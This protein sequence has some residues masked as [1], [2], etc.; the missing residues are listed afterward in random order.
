PSACETGVPA[1]TGYVQ[2]GEV[3]ASVTTFTD[4]NNGNGLN[5]GATYC[6]LIY[7]TFPGPKKGESLASAEVCAEVPI[8]TSVLTNVT[9]TETDQANG[10]ILVRWTQPVGGISNFP[11]PNEYRLYRA[12]GKDGNQGFQ[13]VFSSA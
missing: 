10:E 9:V 4:T 2:I 8:L 11:G 12:T 1:S 7:A 13:Q 5:A 6:Y 3:D